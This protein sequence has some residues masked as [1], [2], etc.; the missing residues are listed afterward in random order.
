[1]TKLFPRTA[2]TSRG[3]DTEQVDTFFARARAAYEGAAS[4]RDFGAH[5]VRTA[6]FDLVRH[7]Y[8]AASVDA[9]LDRL[10]AAFVSAE[11]ADYIAQNGQDAWM[12]QVVERATTLY[13]RLTRPHGQRFAPPT[14][15]RGYATE[16][17]DALLDSLVSYFDE[18]RPI[19]A[20]E[21]RSTVFP[22]AS[23]SKSYDEGTV[24]AFLD[25]AIDVLLAVE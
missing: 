5:S 7:G 10:E 19:T 2:V 17:V 20:A 6:A 14:R 8:R 21:V 15:G 13:E 16:A 24:D 18:G 9:A 11:R 25:R 1:M 4:D 22:S 12:G 23:R 3:Y